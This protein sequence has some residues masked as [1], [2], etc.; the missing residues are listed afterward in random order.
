MTCF[1]V[2]NNDA[3]LLVCKDKAR[4]DLEIELLKD[5]E[6]DRAFSWYGKTGTKAVEEHMTRCYFH[7]HKVPE[8]A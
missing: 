6:R 5:A 8:A 3:P 4:A 7:H 2:F 1:V